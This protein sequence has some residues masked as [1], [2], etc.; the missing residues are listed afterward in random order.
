VLFNAICIISPP[1]E[2]VDWTPGNFNVNLDAILGGG[3]DGDK[4]E[5]GGS[6]SAAERREAD[7][8]RDVIANAMWAQ[9]T[10]VDANS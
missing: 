4:G 3:A 7:A 8:R 1:A 5:L 9:Y 10:A 6:I 2:L